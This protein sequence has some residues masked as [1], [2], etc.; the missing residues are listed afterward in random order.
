MDLIHDYCSKCNR[1]TVFYETGSE[2]SSSCDHDENM[3]D[4]Y[5]EYSCELCGYTFEVYDRCEG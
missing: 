5:I 2:I 1:N 4:I 3:R